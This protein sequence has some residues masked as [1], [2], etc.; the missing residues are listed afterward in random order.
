ML[1]LDGT[2]RIKSF[3]KLSYIF[4]VVYN[5]IVLYRIEATSCCSWV[6]CFVIVQRERFEIML[7][8]FNIEFNSHFL[9][10]LF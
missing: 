5:Q 1:S 8:S 2:M 7:F 3:S 6:L 4:F 10:V 9:K